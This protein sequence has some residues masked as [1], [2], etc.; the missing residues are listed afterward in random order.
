MNFKKL[1]ILFMIGVFAFSCKAQN[2]ST[3][4]TKTESQESII[5]PK[6]EKI[7]NNNFMGAV[8][9]NN[10]VQADSVNQNAVG[11]VTFEP[12]ART[13]WHSHPAGQIILAL[14]GVGYYQEKGS[15]KVIVKKGDVVKCPANIPHWHGASSDTKFI[16]VAIT[17]REK[18][19]TIWLEPV[20]DEQ[21]NHL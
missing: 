7:T 16:Q 1:A 11:S 14:D 18:G 8:W 13:K 5:F 19:E 10:L 3:L 12:G 20:T 4:S 9:L 21:Y 2:K 6:G 17:G 15:P